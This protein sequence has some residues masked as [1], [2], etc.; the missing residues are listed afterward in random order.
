MKIKLTDAVRARAAVQWLIANIGPQQPGAVG[1]VIHGTGWKCW[2]H[3]NGRFGD[4]T[5]FHIELDHHV[6]TEDVMMFAL[7]WS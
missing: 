4:D 2:V 7:K 1:S 3:L 6:D 5:E